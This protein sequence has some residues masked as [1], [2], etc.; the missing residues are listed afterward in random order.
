MNTFGHCRWVQ[1]RL[2]WLALTALLP[3]LAG[4]VFA[5]EETFD[6][7]QTRTGAYTN[8]TVTQKTKS[9]IMILHSRGAGNIPVSDLSDDVQQKLG[10]TAET[11]KAASAN[12]AGQVK[13]MLA[14]IGLSQPQA[15]GDFWRKRAPAAVLGTV[16][17]PAIIYTLLGALVLAY[18]F[19]SYCSMLIC[20]KAHTEPGPLVWLPVL[21]LFPL[22]RAAGMSRMW[23]LAFLL[24]VFNLMAQIV[25][26]VNI[27]RARGKSLWVALLLALPVTGP[28]TFL[29]LAFSSPA[30]LDF[31]KEP[32]PELMVL[33]AG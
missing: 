15:L 20:Q 18:L 31:E 4:S 1:R 17:N 33:D 9:W 14:S 27:V 8:V 24:P 25:W 16:S 12:A 10:Y 26:F 22:L 3:P 6:V 32:E 13:Q 23:F 29:Y 7:L 19:F 2:S 21:Q 28:F 11:E 5:H 30:P